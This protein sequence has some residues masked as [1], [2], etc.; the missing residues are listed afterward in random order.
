MFSESTAMRAVPN[1]AERCVFEAWVGIEADLPFLSTGL[2][3]RHSNSVTSLRCLDQ[4]AAE[5][6]I[7]GTGAR[8]PPFTDRPERAATPY[9]LSTG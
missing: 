3:L 7:E 5:A 4:A 8:S 2:G 1:K 6:R 9:L